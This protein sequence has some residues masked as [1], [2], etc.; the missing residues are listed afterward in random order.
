[1]IAD[2]KGEVPFVVYLL[3]F[4]AGILCASTINPGGSV[5]PLIAFIVLITLFIGFNF[6]YNKLNIYKFA[7]LGGLLFH[8]LLFCA[9]LL[10]VQ[11]HDYRNS[12]DY[13]AYKKANNLIVT[14]NNEPILKGKYWHFSANV[15]QAN[16]SAVKGKMLLTIAAD[17]VTTFSYGDELLVPYNFKPVDPPFNPAVFNYK[18][19]LANQH[20]Y[21]QSF[22]YPGQYKIIAHNA[23]NAVI[24]YSLRLREKLVNLFKTNI[25]DANAAAVASTLILGYKADLS[26]DVLQAYAKT[27]TIHVLSVS[28]AHVAIVFVF[29][30]FALS[31]LNRSRRGQWIKAVV[32]IIFIWAYAMLT[33]FSPAVCRSAIMISMVI[34]GRAGYRNNNTANLLALSAFVLLIYDPLLIADVGF[35]LSYLA[36]LGLIMLQPIINNWFRIENKYGRKIW[37][38]ISASIAAQVI[39]FPLAA[40]YF[41]QFPIYFLV[42]NLFIIIPSELILFS[43]IVAMLFS[44]VPFFGKAIFWVLE[45]TILVMNK[46]LTFIEHQ[47]FATVDKIWFTSIE[48]TLLFICVTAFFY[49]LYNQKKWLLTFSLLCL[50][51]VTTSLTD[52]KVKTIKNNNI[53]FY[54]LNKHYGVLFKNGVSGVLLTDLKPTDAVYKYDIQPGIDSSRVTQLKIVSVN[55]NLLTDNFAKNSGFIRFGDSR[56]VIVS[57]SFS[58]TPVG[59]KLVADV[60]Y[61]TGNPYLDLKD[62]TKYFQFKTLIIDGT[63]S[64]STINRLTADC[65]KT[66]I[67]YVVLKRNKYYMLASN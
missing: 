56:M 32:S 11:Q 34:L 66:G 44:W 48:C 8:L 21:E 61:I 51:I 27:G 47:P 15:I 3:P 23:G 63:N 22:L 31:F 40:F 39:T 37:Y 25:K 4:I 33:G 67:K 52:N 24:A 42:S 43:G 29:I 30:S 12:N 35:Q 6:F 17:N 59:K 7:W 50:L 41:H 9:G 5:I 28:G 38:Y 64:L 60:I 62:L 10:T 13:F 54:S 14:I 2:H 46:G 36:V 45:N 55:D 49:Y 20:I 19:Y 18:A 65:S 16:Q 58:G 57:N 53:T 1:M 26:P